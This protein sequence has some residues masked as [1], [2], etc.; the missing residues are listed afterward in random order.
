MK[1]VGISAHRLV[2]N[3]HNPREVA[4]AT[5]WQKE[6]DQGNILA[7]LLSGGD[8][9]KSIALNDDQIQTA[10]TVIQWL[11][12]N[13]GMSFLEEVIKSSPEVREFLRLRCYPKA[14]NEN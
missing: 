9:R 13:V 14:T 4:F 7:Y 12:S 2:K 6:Q 10:A 3:Q 11:G 5:K 8:N 1:H